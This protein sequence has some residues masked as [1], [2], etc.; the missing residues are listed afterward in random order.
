MHRMLYE[1][2]QEAISRT[3]ARAFTMRKFDIASL[4]AAFDG[5]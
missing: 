4:Q 3:M 2:S 5:A 1:G